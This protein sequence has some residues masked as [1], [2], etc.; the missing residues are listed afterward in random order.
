MQPGFY[1]GRIPQRS[2][3]RSVI[4]ESCT[5]RILEALPSGR[6]PRK[7]A[8]ERAEEWRGFIQDKHPNDDVFVFEVLP[9]TN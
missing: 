8:Q 3:A 6:C 7:D 4:L 2:K 1:V 5:F 9:K